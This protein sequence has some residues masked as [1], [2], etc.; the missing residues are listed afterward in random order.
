[1]IQFQYNSASNMRLR[2]LSQLSRRC[3]DN[4]DTLGQ[5][6]LLMTRRGHIPKAYQPL[7]FGA[8]HC[9]Q[10]LQECGLQLQGIPGIVVE[11]QHS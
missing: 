6:N 7:F 4:W 8:F 3:L 10:V 1:M 5:I 2:N 9:L 11:C